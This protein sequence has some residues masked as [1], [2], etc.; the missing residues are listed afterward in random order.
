MDM[1]VLSLYLV[2]QIKE[3]TEE[4]VDMA[5]DSLLLLKVSNPRY[6]IKVFPE[7]NSCSIGFL[8]IVIVFI[9]I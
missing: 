5:K 1:I 6:N 2:I 7:K 9:H 8:F 3:L 4:N